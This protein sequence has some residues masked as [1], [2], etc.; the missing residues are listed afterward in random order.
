MLALHEGLTRA[1][2]MT[3]I[4]D[5]GAK[6]AT[7]VLEVRGEPS[8]VMYLDGG[9]IAFAGASWVPGLVDRLRGLRPASA[10]LQQVLAGWAADDSAIA[11]HSSA[12]AA[13]AAPCD[14]YCRRAWRAAG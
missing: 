3:V 14:H 4:E 13:E 6:G 7:G 9:H 11:Q 8:G 10:E 2:V 1:R 5:L 12:I